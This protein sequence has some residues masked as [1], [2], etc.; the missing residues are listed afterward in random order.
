MMKAGDLYRREEICAAIPHRGRNLLVDR[1]EIIE[2]DGRLKSRSTL[3][4]DT[5]DPEGRDI[6]LIRENGG[7]IYS[8]FMLVEHVALTSSVYISSQVGEGE[9]AFFSTITNFRGST[10]LPAGRTLTAVV[11]PMGRRGPFH[12]S[13]CRIALPGG[14]DGMTVD[15]MA[16]VIPV[17]SAGN[18]E[19]DKKAASPPVLREARPVDP[20]FFAYKSP[21]L[22]FIQEEWELNVSDRSLT[23][24]YVYPPDHPFVP[25]HF[26]G[27]AVMM[28]V[29][30]WAG[31]LD[32]ALW[33]IHRLGLPA[34][35]YRADGE[36]LR[37]DGTLVTEIKGL[38]F[39]TPE[40]GS[41]PRIL[42]TKRIGFRD[43]VREKEEVFFRVRLGS[44]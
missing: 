36:I 14:G 44:A 34:G 15:M 42:S 30:Q 12:R 5:D 2:E 20:G 17:G 41:S 38:E 26:P 11:T 3:T 7:W 32:A 1:I 31:M 37:A 27:N 35:R 28:G 43:V 40:P 10:V 9:V 21:A 13:R 24:R 25:G 23:A 19:G 22:L 39:Q 29:S 8:E 18:M 6:F 4:V 33:T 16:A